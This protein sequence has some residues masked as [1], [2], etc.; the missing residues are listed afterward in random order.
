MAIYGASKEDHTKLVAEIQ[1][2][3]QQ[4]IE[5]SDEAKIEHYFS[6]LNQQQVI[7]YITDNINI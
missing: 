6:D 2:E 3:L 7:A 1:F 4:A 5:H